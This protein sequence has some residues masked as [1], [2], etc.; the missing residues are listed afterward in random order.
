MTTTIVTSAISAGAG[1]VKEGVAEIVEL[2]KEE[3]TE[4]MKKAASAAKEE[5]RVA[6]IAKHVHEGNTDEY[7]KDLAP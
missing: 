5:A 2:Q 3:N 4:A 6:E 1:I 7:R